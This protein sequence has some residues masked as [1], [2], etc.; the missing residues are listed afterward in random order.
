MDTCHPLRGTPRPH[1]GRVRKQRFLATAWV[2]LLVAGCAFRSADGGDST[3]TS[4][5]STTS[6]VPASAIPA[7]WPSSGIFFAR[8][9]DAANE[10]IR[11][12]LEVAPRLGAQRQI[13]DDRVELDVLV[14]EDVGTAVVKSTL[15]M[16]R[17]RPDG[18]WFVTSATNEHVTIEW[19][20][21]GA[22]VPRETL[23]VRGVARG[24]EGQVSISVFHPDDPTAPIDTASVIA[25]SRAAS[26]PYRA[27]LD[28]S[29][30]RSGSVLALLVRGGRGL[31]QDPGEFT[32]IF[33]TAG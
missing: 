14:G 9:D 10:F 3:T 15:A 25:G 17:F 24:F 2:P 27:S 7:V 29:D 5:A 6:T 32:A 11:T 18:G 19:P 4:Y 13:T 22:I 23:E 31:E 1:T 12:V 16:R 30:V 21:A 33:V 20:D 8:P 28:I 26:E